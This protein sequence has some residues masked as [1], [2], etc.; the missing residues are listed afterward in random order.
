MN[1]LEKLKELLLKN[2][3]EDFDELKKQLKKLDFEFNSSEHIKE[4][5]S[6]VVATAIKESIKSSKDDVVDSLYPIIGNMITKYVSRTFEDMINSI[7]NQ[8]RNRFSFKAISRKLRAKAQ[9]ISETELLIKENSK[10][11][12]KTVFLI[13]KNSGVVLTTLENKNSTIIEPEMV[14]SMLTAIRSFVNDWIKQNEENKELN[15]IDYGGSKI[16]IETATTCYLATIVDGAITKDT[17]RKIEEALA[18]IVSKYGSKI[19]DFN[20]NLDDLP[21]ENINKVLLPLLSY[22]EYIEKNEK[23]HPIIYIFP[24]VILIII[25]YFIYN[26]II[27]SNL[28]KKA[29]ELLFKNP[30]LTIYRL[31]AE[32]KNRDIFING[33]VPN[34]IYKDM[35]FNE[36]KKLDKVK[37]IENNIQVID[38]INNPKDI[39]DKVTYLRMALNQKDGNKIEYSYNYPNLKIFG[40][41]ISKAEKKYVESQFSFIEGL[42]SIDFDIKIIP[43]NIDEVIHF[44]LNSSEISPNQEYKLINI[45]NLLHKLDD[46][47]VL[48]IYGFRDFSGTLE[49]NEALVNERAKTI[50]KYLKLKGN[51]SQKLVSIGLNEV[52]KDIDEKE[53]PEQGRKV[54]FKWK[55]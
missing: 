29:N 39:Y 7:N 13:D 55:K 23:I 46:D 52:P 30:S 49:R 11:Y 37:N 18:S 38:Y 20:G 42:D 21:L 47:L 40:S 36:I 31:E 12:I 50:M 26:Y 53:Y 10:A 24:I 41:V 54:V 25:S 45:I 27:D 32:V 15:T 16:I 4:K 3:L 44:D 35:V 17:Y 8:I 14:A 34:T 43:P 51:I 2:E 33:V 9:G 22:E 19:R 28:E 5:I 48:E 6:P 1:E